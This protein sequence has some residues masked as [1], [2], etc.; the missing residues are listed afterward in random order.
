MVFEQS[1][2]L[3]PVADKLGLTIQ[4]ADHMSAARRWRN[5][6]IGQPN[7]LGSLFSNDVTEQAQY[8]AIEVAPSTC[9]WP[10]GVV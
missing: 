10:C 5:W 3:K 2:S 8:R 6:G 1:D 9:V 7:I 4:T